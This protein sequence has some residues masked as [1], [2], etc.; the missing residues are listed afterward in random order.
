MPYIAKALKTNKTLDY[1]K[2]KEYE[3]HISQI[4]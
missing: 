4:N 1:T 3:V 2:N